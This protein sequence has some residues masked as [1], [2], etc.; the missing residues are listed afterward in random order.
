MTFD[1]LDSRFPNGLDDAEITAL[2]VDYAERVATVRLC[3]RTN[4]PD[5]PDRDLYTRAVLSVREIYYVS[6]EPPEADHLFG[7]KRE[8]I[9][10][11][12]LP[13]D[14]QNFPLFEQIKPKL[15]AGA[16]YC[17]FFVHDWNSFIHIAAACADFSLA[18]PNTNE[19]KTSCRDS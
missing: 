15:P 18:S 1:E 6:I 8:K 7:P 3:L 16:F 9:T 10:V 5:S 14:A 19:M 17:R 13:E 11:D 12:G 4:S 2:T